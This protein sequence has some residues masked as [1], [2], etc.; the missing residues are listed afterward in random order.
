MYC[1]NCGTKNC[2][3]VSF[4]Y[5]CGSKISNNA[6]KTNISNKIKEDVNSCGLFLFNKIMNLKNKYVS[7]FICMVTFVLSMSFFTV[8]C[9]NFPSNLKNT[10]DL[11]YKENHIA[12]YLY[13]GHL[14]QCCRD[15][16]CRLFLIIIFF[17]LIILSIYMFF[18]LLKSYKNKKN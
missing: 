5:N 17:I 6:L 1:Y 12:P 4:C 14:E 10:I 13:K 11:I 16:W 3:E 8:L 7:V 18:S 2:S 9:K 15:L